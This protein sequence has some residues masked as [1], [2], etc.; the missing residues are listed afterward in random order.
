MARHVFYAFDYA[1]DRGRV[2]AVLQ[3]NAL[4]A[5]AEATDAEWAKLKRSGNF[6]IQGWIEEQLK[7]RSCTIVLI[8]AHTAMRSWVQYEIKRS[9]QLKLAL[10]GIH[11]HVLLDEQGKPSL[12]GENPFEHPECGLGSAG[13]LVPVYDPPET[14]S[15]RVFRHITENLARWA[16][17]AVTARRHWQ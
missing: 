14:E 8:G 17:E 15:P 4:E 10:L 3:S 16:D 7:G 11:V 1:A 12:K 13:A 2:N 9:R 5:N 6:A